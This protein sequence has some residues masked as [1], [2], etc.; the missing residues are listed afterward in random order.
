MPHPFRP[1]VKSLRRGPAE[2]TL[3]HLPDRKQ[4]KCRPCCVPCKT[5][6]SGG[7]YVSRPGVRRRARRG[8][9][10]P[11]ARDDC[12]RRRGGHGHGDRAAGP[13]GRAHRGGRRRDVQRH[14]AGHGR[15]DG[16]GRGG[17]P[18]GRPPGRRRRRPGVRGGTV[19][20]H[21]G[22]RA[23]PRPAPR[24]DAGPRAAWRTSPASRP[25]TPA[26]RSATPADEVG[27]GG[28][29]RVLGAAPPN[30]IFGEVVPIQDQGLD[31]MLR[32]PV[33]VCALIVAVE[34]PAR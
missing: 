8:Y 26:S 23:R 7:S 15:R 5:R 21:L 14:R 10:R 25:A 16:G 11:R 2:G 27:T 1:G 13:G 22:H 17:G 3:T 29:A 20:A 33:G 31:V 24:V 9:H 19:A 12:I 30:K 34:L 28:D 18:R 6:C 4:G 32:E